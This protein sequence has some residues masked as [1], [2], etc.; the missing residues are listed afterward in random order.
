MAGGHTY[1]QGTTA[2]CEKFDVRLNQW[3][4]IAPMNKPRWYAAGAVHSDS[5]YVFGGQSDYYE[6]LDD[7]EQYNAVTDKWTYV[8]QARFSV[9]RSELAAACIHDRIYLFGGFDEDGYDTASSV[10]EY[11]DLT[12][13]QIVPHESLQ[14][15]TYWAAAT[16]VVLNTSQ[17]C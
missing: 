15:P 12:N 3:C 7:V 11:F 2:A 8:V 17:V 16:S 6:Y 5:V 9:A 14:R 10:S 4:Q 13:M 1:E